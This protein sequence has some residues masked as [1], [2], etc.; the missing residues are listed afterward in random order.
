MTVENAGSWLD[1]DLDAD[2]VEVLDLPRQRRHRNLLDLAVAVAVAL[3]LLLLTAN[4]DQRAV[5]TL[6]EPTVSAVVGLVH[7]LGPETRRDRRPELG[8]LAL[9]VA[10]PVLSEALR[11]SA[12][13]IAKD[14]FDGTRVCV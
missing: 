3:D 1:P 5:A 7:V 13:L 9:R 2:V 12:W 14:E 8:L 11:L 4:P 10:P 6:L